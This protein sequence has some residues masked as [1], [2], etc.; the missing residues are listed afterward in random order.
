MGLKASSLE[1]SS[2]AL[3]H[4]GTSTITTGQYCSDVRAIAGLTVEDGLGL[5]GEQ[6][7]VAKDQTGIM[8]IVAY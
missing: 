7:D 2:L 4:R 3:V 6:G 5:V 1:I 8:C